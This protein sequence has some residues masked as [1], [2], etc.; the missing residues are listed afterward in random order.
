MA[1]KPDDAVELAIARA[2]SNYP[3]QECMSYRQ[4]T[5]CA[6]SITSC[7]NSMLP[8]RGGFRMRRIER[9]PRL[10]GGLD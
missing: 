1:N 2:A 5:E 4:E 8:S 3:G 6:Q 10:L 7:D 9:R